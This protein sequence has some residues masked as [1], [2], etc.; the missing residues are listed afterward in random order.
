MRDKYLQLLLMPWSCQMYAQPVSC[1]CCM[2]LVCSDQHSARNLLISHCLKL[3]SKIH[4]STPNFTSVAP[5]GQVGKTC[6]QAS[7]MSPTVKSK[8]FL[9]SSSSNRSPSWLGFDWP[10]LEL[11]QHFLFCSQRF[12][13]QKTIQSPTLIQ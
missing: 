2:Q 9:D 3:L 6:C 4:H 10:H 5:H 1:D 8:F 13:Q 11:R 7:M 12:L